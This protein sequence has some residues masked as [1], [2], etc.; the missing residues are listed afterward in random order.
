MKNLLTIFFVLLS[1]TSS[2]AQI[3][4]DGRDATS[5]NTITTAVPFL[6]ITPDTRAGGMGDV[7]VATSPDANSMHWNPA[8]YGFVE[9]DFGISISYTPWL[10]ALIDDINLSYIAGF[11]RID[12][13]Q[14]VGYSLRYFSLGSIPFTDI[15]GT[16]LNDYTP[17]EFSLDAAYSLLLTKDLSAGVSL[18]YVHS[19]L[20]GGAYV[21]GSESHPGTSVAGDLSF[22]YNKDISIAGY[23]SNM[24]YGLN[25]SNIGQKISYTDASIANFLP[26]NM[27]LG[28][29]LSTEI[30]SYNSLSFALDFNKLLVPTPPVYDGSGVTAD[31]IIEG[32][33]PNVTVPTGIFQSFSDAPGGSTEE[34]HELYYSVGLEYWYDQKFALRTGYFHEHETKGNRK[35]FTV[36]LGLKMN[37]FGLDFAYLIPTT[38]RNPLENTL[39]FTISFD[40]SQNQKSTNSS[41]EN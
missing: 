1:I 41:N 37:V 32:Q 16:V 25:I 11:Y 36:G 2:F 10:R 33:D 13:R 14:V 12:K 3:N 18:R 34:M 38:Q 15:N 30:D 21:G 27:R 5:V 24:A 29:S 39:R 7:G 9:G 17:S 20:T 22:Y 31:N 40:L 23:K 8:K 26:T 19:N 4:V 28:A 35:Y 6:M